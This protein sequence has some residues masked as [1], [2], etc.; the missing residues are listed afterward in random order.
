[1]KIV[2][3]IKTQRIMLT[4]VKATYE[5]GQIIWQEK[6]P[7]PER[8]EVIVTALAEP[9]ADEQPAKRPRQGGSMRGEVWMA[10]DFNAPL[11]DLNDYM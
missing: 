6:P 11:A 7:F 9:V 8:T 3:L 10:T 1:L 2:S 5:N 4:A